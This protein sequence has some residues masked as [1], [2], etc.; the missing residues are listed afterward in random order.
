MKIICKYSHLLAKKDILPI[1]ISFR[2]NNILIIRLD[3]DITQENIDKF[4][5]ICETW[6]RELKIIYTL[7]EE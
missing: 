4:L 3:N 7:R 2:K 5:K 1:C 6:F